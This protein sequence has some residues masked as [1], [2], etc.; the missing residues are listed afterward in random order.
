MT[1]QHCLTICRTITY[2]VIIPTITRSVRGPGVTGFYLLRHGAILGN[3]MIVKI[4]LGHV[5]GHG[6]SGA[7]VA[8]KD[9]SDLST[10]LRRWHCQSTESLCNSTLRWF[11][12]PLLLLLLRP[13]RCL[14]C[15]KRSY[16]WLTFRNRDLQSLSPVIVLSITQIVVL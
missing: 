16:K 4:I 15:Y 11:D 14:S 1:K 2:Q 12:I 8:P 13:K 10:T 5:I 6:L 9:C 7:G 3:K